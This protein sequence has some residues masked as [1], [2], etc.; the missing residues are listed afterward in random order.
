MYRLKKGII[1]IFIIFFI[2]NF[3]IVL[4]DSNTKLFLNIDSPAA[5]VIDS[6]TGRILYD[7][8]AN[9]KRKMA[10]LTKVITSIMLVENCKLDELIEVP[11]G[12]TLI[13]GS[14]VGLKKGD[15]VSVESLLYGMLLPSG[16]DCAYTAGYHIG[17]SI[18]NFGKMATKKVNEIGAIN[19][20]VEN[21]HRT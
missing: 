21:P 19:T 18:E 3:S 10:S 5:V 12:A 6:K 15:M 14:T 16:N 2:F 7:K 20:S 17:G 13:G 8:N 11:K 9:E 4:G 1:V